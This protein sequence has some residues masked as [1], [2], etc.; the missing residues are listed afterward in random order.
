MTSRS[1][2]NLFLCLITTVSCGTYFNIESVQAYKQHENH[3]NK[4]EILDSL[5]LR[6]IA[7]ANR[8]NIAGFGVALINKDEVLFQNAYG[9]AN[10]E[11]KIPFT[12]NTVMP[13]ASISKTLA[14]VS[15]M[16]AIE[17]GTLC[18]D[19]RI[20][21]YLEFEVKNPHHPNVDILVRHLATH[22][23]SLNYTEWY[24]HSYI[25]T[26]KAPSYYLEYKGRERK[27]WKKKIERYNANID[28]PMDS[29]IKAIYTSE[30]KWYNPKNYLK[31]TPG[32]KFV[33]CN[34]NAALA[35]IVIER[36]TGL[37]YKEFVQKYIVEPLAM[38]R[39]SWSLSNY[40]VE[41]KG[42]LYEDGRPIPD[43]HLITYPDGGF[44]TSLTDFTNY[45]HNILRGHFGESNILS[46]SSYEVMTNIQYSEKENKS[47]IFWEIGS[48]TMG[49]SGGDP[50]V[51]T[52]A[53]FDEE[54]S[55]GYII[56]FKD[57]FSQ[58]LINTMIEV[59]KATAFLS[60]IDKQTSE[61]SL[62]IAPKTKG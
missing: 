21:D 62:Q 16:K 18:L 3:L 25:M 14:G 49:H 22:T 2:Y 35:S 30:G 13:I 54:S 60:V 24:E 39:S 5:H 46:A 15:I 42:K 9:L 1:V 11:L 40:A 36:A 37:G 59:R 23:S 57:G 4:Q 48:D 34:E 17:L 58:A 44:V 50:G 33:Y 32:S 56:L 20:N 52:F 47:G 10:K 29:F 55:Y 8:S 53:F 38:D 51:S 27:E 41:E 12:K 31:E 61:A 43:Y 6:L 28:M 45:F 26:E 7:I 19:D